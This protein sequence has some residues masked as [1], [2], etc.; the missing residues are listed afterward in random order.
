MGM[1]IA[2]V[3]PSGVG[4]TSLVRELSKIAKFATA[5][6]KHVERP[7][8]SLFKQDSRFAL[9]NQI[10]YLLYRA[11]QE[12][13]LRR[14]NQ[15]G[16]IDGGLDLD[17]HGFSRLFHAR[18]LLTNEEFELCR[19]FYLH[20]R[21]LLPLPELIVHLSTSEEMIHERLAKRN[22]INIASA[23]DTTLFNS[24]FEEW[25]IQLPAGRCLRLDVTNEDIHYSQCTK[26]ILKRLKAERGY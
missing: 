11:E 24:F 21:E 12:R 20:T 10:D 2:I 8:Q 25:L 4:K 22:R 14:G 16:L 13:N 18:G 6:E 19:R 7:F 5:F 1:I 17:F 26:V 9:A 23:E 3:G 15:T